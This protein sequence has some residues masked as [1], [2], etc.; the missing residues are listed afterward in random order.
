MSGEAITINCNSL[1]RIVELQKLKK[2]KGKGKKLF[3]FMYNIIDRV[4]VHGLLDAGTSEQDLA[5][6]FCNFFV[7]KIIIIRHRLKEYSI[8][9][10]KK[11]KGTR[12]ATI[13]SG[14]RVLCAKR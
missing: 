8:F 11:G 7:Y 3:S 12:N 10:L 14:I 9:F 4:K 6:K 1:R 5:S 2:F 13:Q